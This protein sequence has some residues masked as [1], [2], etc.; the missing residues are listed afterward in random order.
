MMRFLMVAALILITSSGLSAQIDWF[1]QPIAADYSGPTGIFA[2][3]MDDDDDIDLVTSRGGDIT[4]WENDGN[5]QFT[6]HFIDSS[7]YGAHQVHAGD[8]DGDGDMDVIGVAWESREIAWYENDGQMSFT[9]YLLVTDYE[10]A[11]FARMYDV[12]GDDDMDIVT[13]GA[14]LSIDLSWWENT[15]YP[16][17]TKHVI[18]NLYDWLQ[19]DVSDL[20]NDG[21]ADILG[22]EKYG[23]QIAW[24]ENDGNQVFQKNVIQDNY[25]R[26][27]AKPYDFNGDS[28]WDILGCSAVCSDIS[29]FENDGYMNFSRHIID[30]VIVGPKC[31]EAADFDLDGDLDIVAATTLADG[32]Y[33]W[34][35]IQDS[36]FIKHNI[37]QGIENAVSVLATDLD[38]DGDMDVLG[39]AIGSYNFKWWQN[40]TVLLESGIVDGVVIDNYG[41]PVESVCVVPSGMGIFEYTDLYGHYDLTLPPAMFDITFQKPGYDE[42]IA[43]DVLVTADVTTTVNIVMNLGMPLIEGRISNNEPAPVESVLVSVINTPVSVYSDSDGVFFIEGLVQGLYDIQFQHPYY[44]DTTITDISVDPGPPDTLRIVLEGSG[45]IAGFVGD[46]DTNPLAGVRVSTVGKDFFDYTDSTGHYFIP[47]IP[48]TNYSISF[49]KVNYLGQTM[50]NI[51]A[52][53]EETLTLDPVYLRPRGDDVTVWFGNLD[54]S[55]VMA[56]IGDTILVDVYV[57][58]EPYVGFIHLPLGTDDQYIIDH[59]SPTEGVLYYPLTD[60]DDVQFLPP[61]ELSP[62]W[63]S[64]SLLGWC[65]IGGDPNPPLQCSDTIQIASFAFEV[66]DDF[67]LIGDTVNCLTIGYS[68]ANHG[69]LFFDTDGVSGYYPYQLFSPFYFV[70]PTSPAVFVWYGHP[71]STLISA[72]IGD[73]I[74]IDVYVQSTVY[75][76][77]D[78]LHLALAAEDQY[79]VDYQSDTA[80]VL[81]YPLTDWDNVQFLPPNEF[82][83]G[84]HSQ[85]LFGVADTG[86]DPN[87]YLLCT[88]PTKIASFALEIANDISIIGDTADCLM[89]GNHPVYGGSYMDDSTGSGPYYPYQIFSSLSFVEPPSP[90]VFVWYGNPDNNFIL[91]PIGDTILVDVYVQ[92]TVSLNLDSLHLALAAEDQYII[93][94]KSD[95]SGVFYY[96]LTDWDNV[97]FLPP[98][99][100]SP[101]WHSQSLLG[102]ADTGGDPNTYLLC[103]EPTKI[104][105]FALEIVNDSSIIGN[106]AACLAAGNH[107]VYSGSFMDDSAG[108]GPYYPYQ[109]FSS[110]YFVEPP[111]PPEIFVWYGNPDSTLISAPIGDTI[112][113][114]VYIQSAG[115]LN[116]DSLHLALA[117]EDQYIVTQLSDSAGVLYHPLTDWDDV[118]FLPPNELSPGWHSQSLVG[119]ADT[120]GASNPSLLCSEPTKIASFALEILNDSSIIGNTADCLTAGSHPVYGG[121]SIDDY[122]GAGPYYPQ[123]FFLP[124]YFV[125][126]LPPPEIFVW[127]GNLSSTPII[128]PIGDTILVDVYVQS[129]GYLDLDSLHLALAAEDQY[130]VDYQSD[131]AGVLYYPLTDWDDVQFLP[132]NELSPGWHSQSL[133]GVADTGGGFN[134][135]LQ[136][137]E[138][139]GIAS[140]ALEIANDTSIIGDIA[141]CLA[142]GN[143]PV[144]G[145]SYMD[146][147]T[148]SGPYYPQEYFSPLYFIGSST[149]ECD[150]FVGDVNNSRSYNGLDVTYGVNFFKGG[151]D[152]ICPFGSC[153]VPTCDIFFYCGDVNGSCSYNG[154]DIT[155]GVNYFKGGANP[156]PCPYCP[157]VR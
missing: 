153:P 47:I 86:S 83:P 42:Y 111:P 56:P 88:E 29:W 62:G 127:Y 144:Y 96:P 143:H 8:L 81:Y 65:D 119:V 110:L 58:S 87:P 123:Q 26:G 120:G 34:E 14:R 21:D 150:Y 105:S 18:D 55:P 128:A 116:L 77:I 20:D 39:G 95:S 23:S 140:F 106:I 15:G 129:T 117:A 19:I 151:S 59:H 149:S 147:S 72:P 134:P 69:P 99:E 103:P 35:N 52:A 130:V 155:Y 10:G 13:S 115:Y 137:P 109:I 75:I 92:S 68:P 36:S 133:F 91:A 1:E 61:N 122:T 27:W 82:S 16:N 148:G 139:I 43:T 126:P 104:A 46:L 11:N 79:V 157:P 108:S 67:S 85:S 60:W 132:P 131:T 30:S 37:S 146:D 44:L 124:L 114:D 6:R 17:F 135:Y 102:V 71:D 97:Q 25:G 7:W 98:N 154:L 3:D 78:S 32:I 66:A 57:R 90:E 101:G 112:L 51:S 40:L 94:Y 31:V 64:Q 54:H 12:D 28:A 74:L 152:P 70:E 38:Q 2:I 107:P 125:E 121:S 48:E 80:G 142:A 76:N 63:H 113:V 24:F 156:I 33:W 89:A 136:C 93:D 84:W 50:Y 49:S 100:L 73:T 4:W 138:P 22:S 9:K 118:Q 5:Q 53:I 145:G 41:S 45:A 141:A